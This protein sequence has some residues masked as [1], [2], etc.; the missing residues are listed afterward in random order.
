MVG[1]RKQ[2]GCHNCQFCKCSTDVDGC[3]EYYCNISDDIPKYSSLRGTLYN[4]EDGNGFYDGCDDK[5]IKI[6]SQRMDAE[7]TWKGKH[8]VQPYGICNN[9]KKLDSLSD[10]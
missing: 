7:W 2:E 9:H 3:S 8:E 10:H 5:A 1:Y 4:K 6:L